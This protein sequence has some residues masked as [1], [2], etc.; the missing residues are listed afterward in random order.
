MSNARWIRTSACTLLLN[1]LQ[2]YITIGIPL[3]SF[4]GN[5]C[6]SRVLVSWRTVYKTSIQCVSGMAHT[7][8]VASYS[9]QHS[10]NCHERWKWKARAMEM[11]ISLIYCI[12]KLR[13]WIPLDGRMNCAREMNAECRLCGK[14]AEAICPCMSCVD[15]KI[16]YNSF[17]EA[18][19]RRKSWNE[20]CAKWLHLSI[21]S[22]GRV[23]KSAS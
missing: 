19:G 6:A 17:F 13:Q 11:E 16:I 18:K 3:M 12:K 2:K 21:L 14:G 10:L 4:H 20:N 8:N 7:A 23:P 9:L 22:S 15:M 1:A 5:S